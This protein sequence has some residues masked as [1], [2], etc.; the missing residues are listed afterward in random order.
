MRTAARELQVES[1]YI[2]EFQI[3]VKFK[4]C[5]LASAILYSEVDYSL[6]ICLYKIKLLA[7]ISKYHEPTILQTKTLVHSIVM[8]QHNIPI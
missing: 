7:E 6:N 1:D 8:Y 3:S 2:M 5:S 4:Q